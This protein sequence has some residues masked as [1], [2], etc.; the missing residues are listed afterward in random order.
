MGL[1][2]AL[3]CCYTAPRGSCVQPLLDRSGRRNTIRVRVK[4]WSWVREPCCA[5]PLRPADSLQQ[6]TEIDAPDWGP[7]ADGAARFL[8]TVRALTDDGVREASALP[9]WARAHV[10]THVAQAADS[11]TGLLRAAR[12]GQVGQQYPSEESRAEAIETGA[13][14][15]VPVIRAEVHR[16]IKE[17]LTAIRE[18]PP[19]LWNAPGVYLAVGRR[20]VRGVVTGLRRELEYHHVD[21]DAGYQPGNWPSD[22]VSIELSG[23]ADFMNRRPDAPPMTLTAPGML[24]VGTRP[25]VD[26]TG[27]PA[28]LLAWLSGRSDGSDLN[29][30]GGVLPALPPL[31]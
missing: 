6:V 31:S 23:V 17:C 12:T 14:R 16:A 4:P 10:L 3:T 28:A 15:P 22:F 2:T 5:A 1:L 27:F 18:H 11:R 19:E 20:P 9:G 29:L 30:H 24:H 8:A 21:L 13:R 25:P 26:V 7:V